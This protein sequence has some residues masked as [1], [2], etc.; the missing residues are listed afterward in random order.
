MKE[1]VFIA[2]SSLSSL[3]NH[4]PQTENSEDFPFEFSTANMWNQSFFTP[5]IHSDISIEMLHSD[6][7]EIKKLIGEI[8]KILSETFEFDKKTDREV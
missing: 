7:D 3:E 5:E 4:I 8:K 1:N 6:L 2:D